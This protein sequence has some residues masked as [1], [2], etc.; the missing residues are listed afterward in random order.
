MERICVTFLGHTAHIYK[1]KRNSV[2]FL[3]QTIHFLFS[4][5]KTSVAFLEHTALE[6]SIEMHS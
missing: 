4:M 5:E 2:T 3:E 6:L 1:W